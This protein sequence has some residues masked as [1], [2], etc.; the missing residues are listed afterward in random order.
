GRPPLPA[1]GVKDQSRRRCGRPKPALTGL[2]LAVHQQRQGL[3]LIPSHELPPAPESVESPHI[4]FP[5]IHRAI[6]IRVLSINRPQ[7][8][9]LVPPSDVLEVFCKP[10]RDVSRFDVTR[11]DGF[12]VVGPRNLLVQRQREPRVARIGDYGCELSTK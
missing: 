7:A 9:T 10:L 3:L 12:A 2:R 5:H 4:S 6:F 11:Q 8:A 1:L